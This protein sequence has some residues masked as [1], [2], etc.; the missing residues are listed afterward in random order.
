M[1]PSILVPFPDGAQ[2]EFVYSIGGKIATNRL[3]MLNRQP[4][5]TQA[6]LDTLVAAA[7]SYWTSGLMPLLASE[8][9]LE[10]VRV[11]S[12]DNPLSPLASFTVP[13]VFGGSSSPT[14]SANVAIR[15]SFQG[16]SGV[17][18]KD[19]GNFIVGIP[20]DQLDVNIYS[21]S[22]GTALF[23]HYAG[24]ID[25]APVWGSFPA[26]RWVVVSLEASGALRSSMFA[27]RV[28]SPILRSPY[29]TQQRHRLRV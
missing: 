13:L 27:R 21:P 19:G 26:W 8:V 23:E 20:D 18:I 17:G 14:Q 10:L 24:I 11:T 1:T 2:L 16:P 3:W 22:F 29:V 12:W 25:A 15:V 9:R 5:T 28:V 6:Q 7:T 4:P